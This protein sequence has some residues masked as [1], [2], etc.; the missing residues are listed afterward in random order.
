MGRLGES[1][2][3]PLTWEQLF[4]GLLNVIWDSL[5]L[6]VLGLKFQGTREELTLEAYR[7]Q[8]GL[9]EDAMAGFKDWLTQRF[10][11]T[12]E[13]GAEIPEKPPAKKLFPEILWARFQ[14]KESL[15]VVAGGRQTPFTPEE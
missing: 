2:A 10:Y 13:K 15:A 7:R 9:R 3:L 5:D 11:L 8:P 12:V 14:C 4:H 1:L 6:Q